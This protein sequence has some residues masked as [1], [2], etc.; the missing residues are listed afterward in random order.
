MKRLACALIQ[1]YQWTLSPLLGAR[2]RFAPS[3]S[4]YAMEAV[5]A[6]GVVK[7]GWL[8]VRRVLRCHPWSKSGYDPVPKR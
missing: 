4:H 1:L 3:C 2:C 7:G 5:T 8:A 6:H